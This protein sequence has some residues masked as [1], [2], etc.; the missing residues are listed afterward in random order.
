MMPPRKVVISKTSAVAAAVTL[1]GALVACL[2]WVA[3]IPIMASFTVDSATMS[4]LTALLFSAVGI[5]LL[6]SYAPSPVCNRLAC[7][8][9]VVIALGG[10]IA[11][12]GYFGHGNMEI[13][14]WLF[15]R[16]IGSKGMAPNTALNFTLVGLAIASLHS[17]DKKRSYYQ[18]LALIVITSALISLIGYLYGTNSFYGLG[19]YIPMAFSSAVLFMFVGVSLLFATGITGYLQV[20]AGSSSGA[21]MARRMLPMA[22]CIPCIL[23]Y[24]RVLGQRAGWYDTEFG[25]A[26]M[27]VITV[28]MLALAIVYTAGVLN[29]TDE[30]RQRDEDALQTAHNELQAQSQL[31]QSILNCMGEGVVVADQQGEI[32]QFNPAA[33][34]ILGDVD[35]PRTLDEWADQLRHQ[36]TDNRGAAALDKLPLARAIR[37]EHVAEK[38]FFLR[39]ARLPDGRWISMSGSPLL[40]GAGRCKGGIVVIRDIS[41]RKRNES[42][43]REA[44]ETLERRVAERTRELSATN[45][46]LAQK[47]QENEMFVYSVSHDLRSPLV[48]LQGFAKELDTAANDLKILLSD[49]SVPPFIREQSKTLLEGDV[50][51]SLKFIQLAVSRLGGIID[52]LLRLSRVGRVE[53][54]LGPVNLEGVVQRILASMSGSLADADMEVVVGQLPECYGDE[55]AIE[56][57]FANLICNSV[58]YRDPSRPGRIEVGW[59]EATTAGGV[60]YYVRDNGLGIPAAHQE[61]IFQAFKRAHPNVASGEGMGLAIVRRTAERHGGSVRVESAEGEGSTFYVTLPVQPN[62]GSVTPDGLQ[63]YGGEPEHGSRTDG[64]LVGGRR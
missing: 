14:Q 5:A 53:Y 32:A 63:D 15:R 8:M 24:F 50:Q 56:Q 44:H 19:N 28:V 48:N 3:G 10:V 12:I 49:D 52:A 37:G 29:R 45:F 6:L 2:G 35:M 36:I 23:G 33:R 60:T 17:G 61:K 51:Q 22:V 7:L 40:D 4:P 20:F 64:H 26:L 1:V 59:T 30:A 11:M 43:L 38:E 55:T 27:V 47:N 13:D 57:L 25:A 31:L 21:V 9:G 54:R 34:R 41:E 58:K 16:P 18:I 62:W 42:I 46:E 39:N